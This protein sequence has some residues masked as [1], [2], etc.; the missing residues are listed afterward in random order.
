MKIQKI[1][2]F[3]V[4]IL[5]SCLMNFAASSQENLLTRFELSNY[6]ECA[7]YE[8]VLEL[9]IKLDQQFSEIHYQ[10]Y[11]KSSRGYDLPMLILDKDALTDAQQIRDKH[12]AIVMIEASIHAGEPDGTS[13]GLMMVRDLVT[14]KSLRQLL[15]SVSIIF[16][17]IVNADAYVRRS[18]YNRIN[19]NGPKEMGWRTNAQNINMNCDFLRSEA[20]AMQ[21]WHK[22]FESYRPDFFMDCHTTNGADYQYAITY[23]LPVFGNMFSFQTEWMINQYLN[24]IKLAME[25]I[26]YPMFRYVSFRQW[27]NPESGIQAWVSSPALSQGYSAIKNRPGI[28]VETHMLKSYEIRVKSTYALMLES[29]KAIASS[30]SE[31]I[32]L[33]EKAD[34][35]TANEEF[36]NS[37]YPV[38]YMATDSVRKIDFLGVKYEK[39]TSELTGGTWYHYTGEKVTMQIDFYDDIVP[40][41]H[42]EIPSAYIIP[43]EWVDVIKRLDIHGIKYE[44][45][46]Y[47]KSFSVRMFRIKNVKF[48]ERPSEGAFMIKEFE[49]D[50]LN[51][52]VVFPANSVIVFT[53]QKNA[54][55]IAHLLDP[56]APSSLLKWGFF[57]AIFEQKEYAENYV[58]EVLAP[59]MINENPNLLM[60]FEQYLKENPEID[61]NQWL[62]LNWFYQHTPYWDKQKDLYPIGLVF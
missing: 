51:T 40:L 20:P 30:P 34:E 8:E 22:I 41:T 42:V 4:V 37:P 6:Q 29:L 56:V 48:S 25:S 24:P 19:Q 38:D 26:G 36:R 3:L 9:C 35:Y 50:T 44:R 46:N 16:L 2:S 11:G 33:N 47:A 53:N 17:P 12:R 14:N 1:S 59:E 54:K 45:L 10:V 7:N 49:M 62:M 5:V 21:A 43:P 15:D 18:P 32:D 58:M 60:E 23:D 28:L 27:H 39:R 57:N 31:L 55:V 52:E 13:A 61:G